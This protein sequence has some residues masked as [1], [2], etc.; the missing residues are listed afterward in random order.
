VPRHVK[1]RVKYCSNYRPDLPIESPKK[2]AHNSADRLT[3]WLCL[4]MG[5]ASV[6]ITNSPS[7]H[8]FTK[9]FYEVRLGIIATNDDIFWSIWA[10]S[11]EN[12]LTFK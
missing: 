7:I 12:L 2:V 10:K 4:P 5:S 3:N 11:K 8:D 1:G 6:L 9:A